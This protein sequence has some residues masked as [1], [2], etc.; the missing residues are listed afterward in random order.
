MSELELDLIPKWQRKRKQKQRRDERSF[1]SSHLTKTPL[2]RDFCFLFFNEKS[3]KL[4]YYKPAV[5]FLN[6]IFGDS[7]GRYIKE[8]L[9]LVPKINGFE[10]VVSKLSD[11][12]L[13]KNIKPSEFNIHT[14][15]G[16]KDR[17]WENIFENRQKLEAK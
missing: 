16:L 6:K 11:E 8:I 2:S 13:K 3:Q 12:E 15:P 1:V 17:P 14:V 5:S 4:W 7:S 9:P 10:E